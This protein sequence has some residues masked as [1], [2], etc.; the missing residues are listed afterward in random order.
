MSSRP[1][2]RSCLIN[3]EAITLM[4]Y[5]PNIDKTE[6]TKN[7]MK[8]LREINDYIALHTDKQKCIDYIESIRN[9][10]VFLVTSER[11]ASDILQQINSLRQVNSVF[12]FCLKPDNAYPSQQEVLFGLEATF[13]ILSVIKD[14]EINLWIIKI[15][16]TDEEATA[17]K[18]YIDLN[19]KDEEEIS[20]QVMFGVLLG[21][22][23]THDES[24]KYYQSLL[25]DSDREDIARIYN[26][27]GTA[28]PPS[29]DL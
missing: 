25:N 22:T 6:D 14:P 16:A 9:E 1:K 21:Q 23:D 5:D 2:F 3:L 12:I 28:Y 11:C 4:W 13:K 8:D 10:K 15:K 29:R 18:D 20:I 26:C 27:I 7:T 17:V 19:R 24:L